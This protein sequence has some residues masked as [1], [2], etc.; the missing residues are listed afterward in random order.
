[1]SEPSKKSDDIM[2]YLVDIAVNDGIINDDERNFIN[3]MQSEIETYKS[4]L[5]KSLE[6][7]KITINE[8]LK[9]V[10]SRKNMMKKALD[11]VREDMNITSDEQKLL[12]GLD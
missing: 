11:T 10:Q 9:L 7:G 2:N 12:D 5:T 1:M 4:D 3:A 8:K 6:D